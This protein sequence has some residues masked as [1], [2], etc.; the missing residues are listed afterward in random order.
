MGTVF[1]DVRR[2]RAAGRVRMARQMLEEVQLQLSDVAGQDLLFDV[3]YLA[4][5]LHELHLQ[6]M[7]PMAYLPLPGTLPSEGDHG[8]GR[9][10]QLSLKRQRTARSL[11]QTRPTSQQ[12]TGT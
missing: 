2:V 9:A 3:A 11:R 1:A 8:R 5:Q 12:T 4:A 7:Q 6:V 10:K